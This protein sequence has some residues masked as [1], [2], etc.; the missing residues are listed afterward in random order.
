VK[1][2]LLVVLSIFIIMVTVVGCGK[3]SAEKKTVKTQKV[4]KVGATGLSFPNAYKDGGKLVG[5]DVEVFNTVAQK[6][7]YKVEWTLTDFAGLM[8]QL[9]TGKI[10]SIA[11]V[12]AVTEERSKKF[13]FS[14]PYCYA[15]TQIVTNKNNSNIKSIADMKGKTVAGVLGSNN[16]KDLQ[17]YD[18]NKDIKIR[19]YETRDGAMADVVNN[20]VD[21]YV[22]SRAILLAEIAK[23]KLPLKFVGNPVVYENVAFPFLKDA[24]GKQ[25]KVEFD[26]ELKKLEKDGTLKKISM[27]YFKEDITVKKK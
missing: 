16:V 6:L 1:K 7:N 13:N 25:L 27:K 10:D 22:N 15:G 23:N 4:I 24:K 26:L 20:R 14:V 2:S 11:N 18:K 19:T 12:V 17:N 5:F 21:G 8:G 3:S 9:Q